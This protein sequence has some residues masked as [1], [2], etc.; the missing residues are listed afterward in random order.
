M[1]NCVF[2][3]KRWHQPDGVENDGTVSVDSCSVTCGH[4]MLHCELRAICML[5]AG[6]SEISNDIVLS[7]CFPET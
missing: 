2:H 4:E 3:C 1:I 5:E 7:V 6:T